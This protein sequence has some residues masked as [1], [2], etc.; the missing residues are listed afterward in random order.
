M[1]ALGVL[2]W[3][4]FWLWSFIFGPGAISAGIVPSALAMS[5]DGRYL[6]V[7]GDGPTGSALSSGGIAVIDTKSR[8]VVKTIRIGANPAQLA[9]ARTGN[10][11]Y[12][13]PPE[14]SPDA[15]LARAV[16]PSGQVGKQL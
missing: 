13:A 14:Y 7:A 12:I 1:A 4:G 10:T 5:P 9:I 2:A 15:W 8:A 6:Y 11:L 16:L 3:A